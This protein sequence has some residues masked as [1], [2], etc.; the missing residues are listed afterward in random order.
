MKMLL[1]FHL[2]LNCKLGKLDCIKPWDGTRKPRFV[3]QKDDR[4]FAHGTN[5]EWYIYKNNYEGKIIAVV[6]YKPMAVKICNYL[7][8]SITVMDYRKA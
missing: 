6:K 4:T 3:V 2:G 1:L 8:E 5:R 7:N